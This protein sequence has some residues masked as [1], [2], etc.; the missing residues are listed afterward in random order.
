[1][2]IRSSEFFAGLQRDWMV[3][4]ILKYGYTMRLFIKYSINVLR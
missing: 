1:M 2:Y 3:E 4:E